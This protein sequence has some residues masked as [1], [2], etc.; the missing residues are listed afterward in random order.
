MNHIQTVD[1][2]GIALAYSCAFKTPLC[3][4]AGQGTLPRGISGAHC[5]TAMVVIIPEEQTYWGGRFCTVAVE[6]E[7]NGLRSNGRV[8]RDLFRCQG[9][10]ALPKNSVRK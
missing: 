6:A 9:Q 7:D 3:S 10:K 5:P 2:L 8:K 4:I 1:F